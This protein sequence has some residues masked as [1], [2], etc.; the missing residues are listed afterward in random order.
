MIHDRAQRI[1]FQNLAGKRIQGCVRHALYRCS[2]DA[3]V[4]IIHFRRRSAD[5]QLLARES[6][7][8]SCCATESPHCMPTLKADAKAIGTFRIGGDLTVNRLG[9]GA[10]RITGAG[11]WGEPK[12][13]EEARRVLQR[14]IQLGVAFIDTAESYGPEVSERLIGEALHPYPQDLVIATKAGL[15]RQGPEQWLHVGRPEYLQQ[16][17]EMSLRR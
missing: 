4:Y 11:I 17:L 2:A 10:M 16:Q 5:C 12:N 7:E 3:G 6:P 8:T 9:F 15:T 1:R 14:T 13:P